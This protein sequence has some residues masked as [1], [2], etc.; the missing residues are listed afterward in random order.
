MREDDQTMTDTMNDQNQN[1]N[2]NQAQALTPEQ[3]AEQARRE[4]ELIA[5]VLDSFEGTPDARLKDLMQSLVRHLHAFIRDVRLTEAEWEQAIEFLT[6]VGHI[7]DDRRQEFVLLSDVLGA[8]M[9]TIAV[10]N[11]A[12]GDATE[13]TVF[14]PFFVDDAPQI[15][16]GQDISGGAHGQPSWIEGT[17]TDIHGE[18][19]EGAR[20]EVWEADEDGFYDVQYDDQR[21]AGRAFLRSGE[22]GEYAFWGLTP[23][24][25]PIPHDG[26]VGKML[27]ATHRSPVRAAHLHFMVTA[28]GYRTL[29][30]HIF[31][32]GDP[33]LDIGDSVFGVKDSLIKRFEEQ[34]AGTPTP[35]GRDLG[36]QTWTKARFDIVL[37]E[38]TDAQH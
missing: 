22:N 28:P 32:E 24:P 16:H 5:R 3:A 1:Q 9:Q 37:A 19:I 31:V 25:Y 7:T 33:Q 4:E 34:P 35:N 27:E 8:S 38:H 14:G 11:P 23:T 6:A 18:P 13:A 10:N 20:I 36:D 12:A 17:V 21:V 29:V 26:P 2:Q 15:Q 30:T